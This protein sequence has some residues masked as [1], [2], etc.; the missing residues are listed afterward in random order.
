MS[1]RWIWLGEASL[2]LAIDIAGRLHLGGA[3]MIRLLRRISAANLKNPSIEARW[4][5]PVQRPIACKRWGGRPLCGI[6]CQN[7]C[8]TA[9]REEGRPWERLA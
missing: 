8:V 3:I 9:I 1:L 2:A 6:S 5:M 7:G 4:D